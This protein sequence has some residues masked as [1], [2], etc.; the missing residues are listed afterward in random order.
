M[1]RSVLALIV[2]AASTSVV[3]AQPVNL[4]EKSALGERAQFTIELDLKGNLIVTLEKGKQPIPLEAKGTHRLIERVMAATDGLPS[5][6]A[7]YYL[8]ATAFAK[9][10]T[11]KSE[12]TLSA[13]RRLIIARRMSDGLSCFSPAGPLTREELDLVMDHF[14]PQCLPGLLPG[15]PVNVGD[16]WTLSEAAVQSACLFDVTIKASLTGK[17]VAVK[18]GVA[19]FTI[20][21]PAEGI[22]NGAKVSL[23]VNATGSFD[24]ASGHITGLTW[25]Q[26]DDREQ[27]AVNP[28][29][30]V[31]ATV[32][33]KREEATADIK[34]LSDES[35]SAITEDKA[36]TRFTNLRQTDPKGRYRILH[37]RDWHVTGQTDTHLIMRL[38]DRGEFIAQAT[39]SVWNKTEP[40]KHLPIEDFKKAVATAP[41]WI[42]GKTTFDRELPATAGKWL[43]RLTVEGKME[44]VPVIQTFYLLAGQ[45][46]EQIVVTVAVKP[47][48][49]KAL[50]SQDLTLVNSIE[51]GK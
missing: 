6:S 48:K 40:G 27:G 30:Q 10:A 8:G 15:K 18:D 25:K 41:G 45:Q 33:L 14:N 44:D 34:E 43:Y 19:T 31:E 42:P 36:D 20:S 32:T 38:L 51:F 17:L 26:K 3:L 37:S 7:R 9:L 11:D 50:A 5:T 21:G 49:A 12:R 35:L 2:L 1:F 46:G 16:T 13:D 4:T 28:A 29:S 22:E 23:A 47:E 24:V 39:V